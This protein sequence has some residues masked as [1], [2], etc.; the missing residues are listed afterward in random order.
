MSGPTPPP[1]TGFVARYSLRYH[2]QS[3]NLYIYISIY[4]YIYISIYLYIYISMYIHMERREPQQPTSSRFVSALDLDPYRLG[5]CMQLNIHNPERR[6]CKCT[7]IQCGCVRFCGHVLLGPAD[8]FRL[9]HV[10][11]YVFVCV[12]VCTGEEYAAAFRLTVGFGAGLFALGES[13]V[14]HFH[15][16]TA[17]P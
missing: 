1:S 5:Y 11:V 17:N 4:L 9:R 13:G 10:C 16:A 2:N 12:Y 8:R 6:P 3:I 14:I 7:S 15:T